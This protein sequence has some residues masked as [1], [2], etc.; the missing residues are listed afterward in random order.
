MKRAQA[1]VEFVVLSSAMLLAFSIV[2]IV[3]QDN[4]ADYTSEGLQAGAQSIEETI[5]HEMSLAAAMPDGYERRFVLPESVQGKPYL[6]EAHSENPPARDWI[7]ISVAGK[8]TLKFIDAELVG[9]L[10][11]GS[12]YMTKRSGV[13]IMNMQMPGPVASYSFTA[14]QAT[15]SSGNNLH[16]TIF[17]AAQ[18]SGPPNHGDA[19]LFVPSPADDNVDLPL[20]SMFDIT[21]DL[22][23][24]AWIKP[25]AF[26][27]IQV[28][29]TKEGPANGYAAYQ[30]VVTTAAKLRYYFKGALPGMTY[31]GQNSIIP[32][33]WTHVALVRE[34]NKIT[35]YIDG[36]KDP[37]VL[38]PT[39]VPLND[40]TVAVR[41]GR[42]YAP[43]NLRPFNG[44]IDEVRIYNQ[45]LTQQQVQL[46]AII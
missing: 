27:T 43:A 40:P 17:G 37:A 24:T 15:D 32:G 18:T 20:N 2:I 14:H 8:S 1:A 3:M 28:I 46:D 7:N 11:P 34:N 22:T 30:F 44:G 38:L 10:Q 19:L 9:T 33:R 13:M 25:T 29:A 41:I 6:I 35:F 4:L 42:H 23:I 21:G 16:G 31:D 39:D 5:E 36:V 45:A 26:T 12:N